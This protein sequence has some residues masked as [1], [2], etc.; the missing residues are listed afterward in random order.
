MGTNTVRGMAGY[1]G[2]SPL[3]QALRA[4][5]LLTLL[6]L[7][8]VACSSPSKPLPP[9]QVLHLPDVVQLDAMTTLERKTGNH[10]IDSI[11]AY[12]STGATAT[13]HVLVLGDGALTD[14]QLDGSGLR[15]INMQPPCRFLGA[16]DHVGTHGLC[17]FNGGVQAFDVD[18]TALSWTPR[19]LLSTSLAST[20][21]LASPTIAPDGLHFAALYSASSGSPFTIN[22]YAVD[23]AVTA[24]TL[25]AIIRLPD[26]HARRLFW[27]PDGKWLAFT[28]DE[29]TVTASSGTTYAFQVASVLTSL[30]MQRSQ[31]IQITLGKDHLTQLEDSIDETNVWRPGS[32]NAIWTYIDEGTIWQIDVGTGER[33]AL[34][35]VPNG[36][37]CA[38][39][40]TP[41]GKQ[42]VFVQCLR[43]L[44]RQPPPANLYVF[45]P[46]TT[47]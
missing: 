11:L 23:H 35:T 21:A 4:L 16:I 15:Q 5:Y 28:S 9:L 13:M 20:E 36:A 34:L 24:A 37:I 44:L 1:S 45:T 3:V 7:L 46:R 27:S 19:V 18:D 31:P 32:G 43:S 14:I 8:F 47:N 42:L 30:P 25:V 29:T 22:I 41:D 38:L 33:T 6:P 40:W 26:L 17:W 12:R 10:D 39:S 2:Y